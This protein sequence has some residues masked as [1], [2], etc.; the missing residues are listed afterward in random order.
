[1]MSNPN[2]ASIC[3]LVLIVLGTSS[4]SFQARSSPPEVYLSYEDARPIIEALRDI[5]PAELRAA[6]PRDLPAL[7]PTWVA[8]RD[9]EIRARLGQGD[10]DSIVNSLLFGTTFTRRPRITL[11]QLAQIAQRATSNSSPEASAFLEAIN[12]RVDDLIRAASAPG[13]NERLLFA[14]QVLER[15]GYKFDSVAGKEQAK[16]FVLASL[17]RVLNEQATYSKV[18]ESAKL[19]GDPSSEFA[20]RSKL[21]ATRGLSS[22]T[23]LLPNLAIER[24]LASMKSR[25]L[26]SPSS[27][28]RVGVIGPGLD[29]TDKQ[30]GY[31]FYPQQTI[32]P[33]AVI[34]S[35]LRLGLARPGDLHIT[36]FDLSARVNE[37]LRRSNANAR[38]GLA[39]IIQ[40]PR[41]TQGQWKPESI[42]YWTKFGDQIGT[43]AKPVTVPAGLGDLKI[44]AVSVRPA[45]ASLVT[46]M[47]TNIVLQHPTLANDQL[48]DV[49]IATNI[50]VYY[51]VFEQCL[52]LANVEKM[53][54]PGGFLLSNNALLEL[55][56]SRIHSVGYETVVYSDKP[57]DGDHIVWYQLQPGN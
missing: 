6:N 46:P 22:D 5:L 11:I 10:E 52:A 28:R 42:D 47:D 37:H 2:R 50:L 1:M 14:R 18:L 17:A 7:W 53:L 24:S 44:R 33:F 27:V 41:D 4:A 51:D 39:Y 13:A 30:D 49:L 15:K 54:R 20:E 56:S 48:F 16:Q 23:S 34:D 3:A 31:D 19:L 36:T 9:S 55:P 43:P 29:F 8:R 32:Q 26:L 25:G 38:Q 40:L 35:L 12:A 45:I 57:D 21:F